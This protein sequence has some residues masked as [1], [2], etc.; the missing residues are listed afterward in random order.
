MRPERVIVEKVRGKFLYLLIHFFFTFLSVTLHKSI[1]L[2]FRPFSFPSMPPVGK[3]P[4]S[5]LFGSLNFQEFFLV[6]SNGENR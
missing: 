2:N 6:V 3:S 5:T 4:L 1:T